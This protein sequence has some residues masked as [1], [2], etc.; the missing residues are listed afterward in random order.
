MKL[1]ID[2]LLTDYIFKAVQEGFIANEKDEL[3]KC[4]IRYLI[5]YYFDCSKYYIS[6]E[7]QNYPNFIIT[8]QK[9]EENGN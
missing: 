7:F 6:E 8:E 9:G 3:I 1:R 4:K 5:N 2:Y